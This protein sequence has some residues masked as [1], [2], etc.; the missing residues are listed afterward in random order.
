[1]KKI[2]L[3]L[4]CFICIG[5]FSQTPYEKV[6]I[7]STPLTTGPTIIYANKFTTGNPYS[8][9]GNGN[10]TLKAATEIQ[11]MPN[12]TISGLTNSGGFHAQ[13]DPATL[14]IA[15]FHP[16]GWSVGRFDRFEIGIKLPTS[17]DQQVEEFLNGLPGINPYNMDLIRF[18][19]DFQNLTTYHIYNREGFYYRDISVSSNSY[20][21]SKSAYPFR[22]RFAPPEHGWYSFNLRLVLN[23]GVNDNVIASFNGGQFEVYY[24]GKKGI[25]SIG[26]NNHFYDVNENDF[27][28][29]GQDFGPVTEIAIAMPS[30]FNTYRSYIDN[31]HSNGGNFIRL[32]AQSTDEFQIEWEELGVYGS[33]R[34]GD[35]FKR[36]CRAYELDKVFEKLES[37]EMYCQLLLE[38]DQ[39]TNGAYGGPPWTTSPYSVYGDWLSFYTNSSALTQYKKRLRYIHARY[40]YSAN[41]AIYETNN[42]FAN[43]GMRYD[44]LKNYIGGPNGYHFSSATRES[45]KTWAINVATYLKS[46]VTYPTHLTTISFADNGFQDPS[47]IS[48]PTNHFSYDVRSPHHYGHDKDVNKTRKEKAT[49]QF[50]GSH[51]FETKKPVLFGELGVTDGFHVDDCFDQEFHN[52]MW[53]SGMSGTT[54][55]GLYRYG[56]HRNELRNS[57]LP[58]IKLFFD[59]IPF[60]TNNFSPKYDDKNDIECIYNVNNSGTRAFGW[61]HNKQYYWAGDPAYYT[62]PNHT[63][64][65]N[66]PSDYSMEAPSAAGAHLEEITLK[67][68]TNI[69]T[70]NNGDDF[71]FEIWSCYGTYGMIDVSNENV[72]IFGNV[73]HTFSVEGQLWGGPNLDGFPD[74]AFKLYPASDN[75]FR[76]TNQDQYQ[77]SNIGTI[78][79]ENDTILWSSNPIIVEPATDP[80][81]KY[82]HWD[83]GNGVTS[84]DPK[85]QIKYD[86]PGNYHVTYSTLNSKGDTVNYNQTIVLLGQKNSSKI[87]AVD[88]IIIYPNPTTSKI[89]ISYGL[90]LSINAIKVI[91]NTGRQILEIG[92]T[93]ETIDLGKYPDGLYQIIFY[94]DKTIITK[95]IVKQ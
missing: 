73:N 33:N 78:D 81:I 27:F 47:Q 2:I 92:N 22:L 40:G 68:F 4:H 1:M 70:G 53:T 18:E 23:D 52:G 82:H 46:Q 9:S 38:S 10:L 14:D 65:V 77:N 74:Y 75:S 21:Q 94:T 90:G 17:I 93:T 85:T 87:A 91:D 24:T 56:Y 19:A 50:L 30:T 11:M 20:N 51:G 60:Q 66:P 5:L 8:I 61:V 48:N 49:L 57:H 43:L 95:K 37:N 76:T 84:N 80:S 83:F 16:N 71:D 25:I 13:I 12:T 64:Q 79:M 39:I 42:E 55:S 89:N 67:G 34:L 62:N 7:N 63:C 35:G 32:N 29:I 3:F 44:I 54:G 6:L 59:G 88:N 26:N 86:K 58:A 15:S 36:Q 41:L 45:A 72:N 69:N 28:A 31:L